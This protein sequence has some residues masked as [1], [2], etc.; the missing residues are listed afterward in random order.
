MEVC[1]SCEQMRV[2]DLYKVFY[3]SIVVKEQVWNCVL[4]FCMVKIN[5]PVP[6]FTLLPERG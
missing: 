1:C 6:K 4:A 3:T 5:V 2:N